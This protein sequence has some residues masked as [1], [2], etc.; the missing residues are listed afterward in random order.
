MKPSNKLNQAVD[1]VRR[2]ME[3]FNYGLYD[4]FVY[5]KPKVAK[6]TY[7]Y[8][9]DVHS[10]I[11]HILGNT[12]VADAI[13]SYVSPIVSLLSVKAC[14]M[15]EPI[16]IDFNYIEVK[17]YGTCFNIEGKCFELDPSGIVGKI[18]TFQLF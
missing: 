12:E 1:V 4:G 2:Y 10:F 14:R 6:F 7:V 11:H 13:V 8:C 15:I 5:K 3:K 17:P 9:S 18:V 16:I